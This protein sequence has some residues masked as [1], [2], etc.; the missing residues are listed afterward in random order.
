MKKILVV[1][2]ILDLLK[3]INDVLLDNNYEVV[4][5]EDGK[6]EIEKNG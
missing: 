4:S 5:C 2:D 1:D 6:Q 3:V